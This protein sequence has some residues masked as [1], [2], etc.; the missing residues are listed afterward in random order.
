MISYLQ[1]LPFVGRDSI[2]SSFPLLMVCVSF[3]NGLVGSPVTML[4]SGGGSWHAYLGPDPGEST[5]ALFFFSLS[6][7]SAMAL[8]GCSL[9]G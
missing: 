2:T 9:L 7:L 4:A 1:S 6:M 8:P 5:V 3:S